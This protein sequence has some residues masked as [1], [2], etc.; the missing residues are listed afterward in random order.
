SGRAW[1]IAP[2]TALASS[3]SGVLSSLW[4]QK[5]LDG[6]GRGAVA[7]RRRKTNTR[8]QDTEQPGIG[9]DRP[10]VDA[11]AAAREIADDV[12]GR[13]QRVARPLEDEEVVAGV[14]V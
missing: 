4:N 11:V 2:A 10:Q 13:G 3:V 12:A 14:A 5:R 7:P 9:I 1:G 6:D 8:R